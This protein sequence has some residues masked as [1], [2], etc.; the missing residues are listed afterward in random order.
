MSR[1]EGKTRFTTFAAAD[2]AA[3]NLRRKTDDIL[4]PYK[5]GC[6]G[7][8]VGGTLPKSEGRNGRPRVDLVEDD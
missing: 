1:C 7:Y 8:H 4:M 5:C 6:G 3:K 2:K